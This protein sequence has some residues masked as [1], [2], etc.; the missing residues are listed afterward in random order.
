MMTVMTIAMTTI[1][2]ITIIDDGRDKKIPPNHG[3]FGG[4]GR[5]K[6]QNL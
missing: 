3:R 1:T 4:G 2:G 5:E 6:N